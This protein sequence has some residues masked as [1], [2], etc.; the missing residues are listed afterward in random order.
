MPPVLQA[1]TYAVP[2]RYFVKVLK[3]VFLKGTPL[4]LLLAEAALLTLFGAAMFLVAVRKF[5][6][7]IE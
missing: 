4:S 5:N 2:S 3:G 6:K 1:A 7:R